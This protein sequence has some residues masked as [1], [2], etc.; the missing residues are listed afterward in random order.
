M[1]IES[2][3][4]KKTLSDDEIITEEVDI[5]VGQL[6]EKL[7]AIKI[8]K[9]K[10]NKIRLESSSSHSALPSKKRSSTKKTK[11]KNVK[12]YPSQISRSDTDNLKHSQDNNH[13]H[14]S[15]Y[16]LTPQQWNVI[17]SYPTNYYGHHQHVQ[18]NYITEIYD[19]ATNRFIPT[20]CCY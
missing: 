2:I 10:S 19:R 20:T 6:E 13:Q 8:S 14:P 4:I 1:K 18:I 12:E 3:S 7:V 11:T 15:P 17:N 5:N 16:V 9:K